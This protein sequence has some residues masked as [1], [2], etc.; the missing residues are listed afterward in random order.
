[1]GSKEGLCMWC[2]RYTDLRAADGLA[3]CNRPE[4]IEK[5]VYDDP[6]ELETVRA[7]L[8]VL[9]D[10]DILISGMGAG[11]IGYFSDCRICGGHSRGD[12]DFVEPEHKDDCALVRA[13]D[14]LNVD[15]VNSK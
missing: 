12:T 1:M 10:P 6:S 13:L 3:D 5:R 4:C 7:L 9:A 2:G 8:K 15:K 14:Y 11:D